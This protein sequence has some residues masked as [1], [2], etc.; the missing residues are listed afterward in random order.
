MSLSMCGACVRLLVS[1]MEIM[2]DVTSK[3]KD[4]TGANINT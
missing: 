1:R 3:V 4:W 2:W